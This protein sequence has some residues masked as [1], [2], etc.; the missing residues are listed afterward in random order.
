[1]IVNV[2]IQDRPGGG[3]RVSSDELP[4]LIL[5]GPDRVKVMAAIPAA[6]RA[7]LHLDRG[8]DVRVDATFVRTDGQS[9]PTTRTPDQPAEHTSADEDHS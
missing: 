5:S 9:T 2:L 4:G 3:I 8:T 7:L 6:V 1:M